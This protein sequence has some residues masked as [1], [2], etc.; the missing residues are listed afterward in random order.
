[1]LNA[2][3]AGA[4]KEESPERRAQIP[5]PPI[6]LNLRGRGKVFFVPERLN[7]GSLA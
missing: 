7:D 3:L 2:F 4:N 5:R 1:M 6:G